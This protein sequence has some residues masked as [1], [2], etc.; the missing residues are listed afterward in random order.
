M[1]RSARRPT[2]AALLRGINLGARNKVSMADVS[3][4]FAAL[5]AEDV[6]SAASSTFSLTTA[7]T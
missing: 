1:P 4:L 6:D 5:D 3:E 2:S 7:T